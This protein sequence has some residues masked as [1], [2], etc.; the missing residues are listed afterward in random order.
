VPQLEDGLE[1]A[2]DKQEEFSNIQPPAADKATIEKINA[3]NAEALDKLEQATD[4][5]RDK[6]LDKF[7]QLVGEE[8]RSDNR[9]NAL[10]KDYGFKECG[11]SANEAQST[12]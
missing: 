11:S 2:R 4:A 12:S 10:A 8:E 7:T 5:A 9:V 6:D 1:W 3:G